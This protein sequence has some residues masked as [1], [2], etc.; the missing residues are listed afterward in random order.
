MN[1]ASVSAAST[2]SQSQ[3]RQLLDLTRTKNQR[4]A[5]VGSAASSRGQV[6]SLVNADVAA[7]QVKTDAASG[8]ISSDQFHGQLLKQNAVRSNSPFQPFK[9][10]AATQRGSLPSAS[11]A[12]Q[13]STELASVSA[14][15]RTRESAE[16][17]QNLD[18]VRAENQR[19]VDTRAIYV[20]RQRKLITEDAGLAALRRDDLALQH[21]RNEVFN[22]Q[23]RVLDTIAVDSRIQ[24]IQRDV[25]SS[26]NR[27]DDHAKSVNTQLLRNV[28]S[29]QDQRLEINTVRKRDQVFRQQQNNL[30]ARVIARRAQYK[31]QEILQEF[32]LRA[33]IARIREPQNSPNNAARGSFL[34][35]SA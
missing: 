25:I 5:G 26:V 8:A 27:I 32:N 22:S 20:E 29:A 11:N 31:S 28:E 4:N 21:N 34:D 19:S 16:T 2:Q 35:V 14:A 1:I 17:L 6:L 18:D 30:E 24:Q 12:G 33:S 13:P 15:I 9:G 10:D 3:V 7:K 23:E